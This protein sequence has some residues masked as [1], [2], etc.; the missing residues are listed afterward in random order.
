MLYLMKLQRNGFNLIIKEAIEE[1]EQT[2]LQIVQL[3]H[4][5]KM[6]KD[7]FIEKIVKLNN[8]IDSLEKALKE[9]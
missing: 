8:K 2:R 7:E 3:N 1:E 4:K 6:E 9:L 5:F